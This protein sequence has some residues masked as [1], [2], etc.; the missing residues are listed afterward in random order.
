MNILHHKSWHVYNKANIERVRK[1][2]AEAEAEAKKKQ[3][4]ALLA[5]SEARL[6]LLRKKA[7]SK[8]LQQGDNTADDQKIQHVNLFQ[9]LENKGNNEEHEAEKNEKEKKWERQIT[10]YLDKGAT[11]EDDPW[12]VKKDR[13]EE[14]YLDPYTFKSNKKHK[15]DPVKINDDPLHY[16]TKTLKE[17]EE[18]KN[19]REHKHRHDKKRKDKKDVRKESDSPTIEELRARRLERER[20]EKARLQSLYLEDEVETDDRKRSYNSQFNPEDTLKA[21]QNKRPRRRD[22]Y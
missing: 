21:K 2:E 9:D 18:K 20:N 8:L 17:R 1:D 19:K 6:T 15:R 12:Y 5:E 4:R 7:E 14:K 22:N 16:I 3:E 13:K 11:K 10:M